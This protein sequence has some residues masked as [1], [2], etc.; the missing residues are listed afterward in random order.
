M[1]VFPDR[2]PG[3]STGAKWGLTPPSTARVNQPTLQ[4]DWQTPLP[5]PHILPA[6]EADFWTDHTLINPFY[7][8]IF[9]KLYGLAI[10]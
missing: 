7:P 2:R 8:L 5:T 6:F 3:E 10:R 4:I 1:T 9:I